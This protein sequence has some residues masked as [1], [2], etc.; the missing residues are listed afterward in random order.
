MEVGGGLGLGIGGWSGGDGGPWEWGWGQGGWASVGSWRGGVLTSYTAV[1]VYDHR[2]LHPYYA[3]TEDV[4][5]SPTRQA[6]RASRTKRRG[7]FGESHG[8]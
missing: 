3:W 4:G 1:V 2:P 7:V 6:S 5:F 8:I